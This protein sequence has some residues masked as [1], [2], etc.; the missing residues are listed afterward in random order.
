MNDSTIPY[1]IVSRTTSRD[2]VSGDCKPRGNGTTVFLCVYRVQTEGPF[3]L[4]IDAA[5]ISAKGVTLAEAAVYNAPFVV[6]REPIPKPVEQIPQEMTPQQRAYDIVRR[7]IFLQ[8]EG[9]ALN[10]EPVRT[11]ILERE[12]GLE[13]SFIYDTLFRDIYLTER[14]EEPVHSFSWYD[15]VFEYLRLGFLY[16]EADEQEMLTH[17]RQSVQDGLVEINADKSIFLQ[18]F[19]QEQQDLRKDLRRRQ[20]LLYWKIIDMERAALEEREKDASFD[21][22]AA[23]E[24]IFRE[25]AGVS[26]DIA[27]KL[28]KVYLEEN[29]NDQHRVESGSYVY[30]HLILLYLTHKTKEEEIPSILRTRFRRG[31]ST[32]AVIQSPTHQL[33]ERHWIFRRMCHCIRPTCFIYRQ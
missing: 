15:I 33:L 9:S 23:R 16:P 28:L 26:L 7:I 3:G 11:Q 22:D 19:N 17:F 8:N 18:K 5:T 2:L 32:I 31:D 10:N 6:E 24:K 30:A 29:P 12:T 21:V 4:S 1:R 27:N 20:R 25:E 14:P 13:I